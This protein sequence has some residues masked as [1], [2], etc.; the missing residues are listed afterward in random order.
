M[1]R[2]TAVLLYEHFIKMDE[3]TGYFCNFSQNAYLEGE[4]LTALFAGLA[5]SIYLVD[6]IEG[7]LAPTAAP[8]NKYYKHCILSMFAVS[9]NEIQLLPALKQGYFLKDQG[10]SL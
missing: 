6:F 7:S 3:Y 2:I 8:F 10:T 5:T 1:S 4:S 9:G